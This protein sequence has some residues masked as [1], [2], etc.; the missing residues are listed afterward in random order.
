[1]Q[2]LYENANHGYGGETKAVSIPDTTTG[3][4]WS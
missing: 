4:G 1:M 2:P 3:E